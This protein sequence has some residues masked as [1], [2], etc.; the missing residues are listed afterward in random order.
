MALT[1]NIKDGDWVSV[2]QAAAKLG[3]IKLG[4]TSTPTYAGLTLTGLTDTHVLYSNASVLA[5][6][7]SFVWDDGAA[8]ALTIGGASVIGLNSVVFQPDTDST[9]FFQILD[10]DGSTPIFNV[11]STNEW[12]GI[13]RVPT[14]RALEIEDQNSSFTGMRIIKGSAI[15]ELGCSNNAFVVFGSFSNHPLYV[16]QNNSVGLGISTSKFVAIGGGITNAE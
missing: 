8:K 11:D 2:R 14:L 9:T 16:I 13:G 7:S 5:G 10:Q 15:G 4:P 12:V 3:S 6:D 1:S